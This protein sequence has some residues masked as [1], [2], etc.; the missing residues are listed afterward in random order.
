MACAKPIIL[1]KGGT[2]KMGICPEIIPENSCLLV[3]DSP[4]GFAKG[5]IYLLKNDKT[6]INIGEKARERI[7]KLHNWDILA[8]LY[9][10]VL[11]EAVNSKKKI[12]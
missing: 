6:R 1:P 2:D 12:K 8:E 9:R 5:I 11:Y 7:V 4:E 10:D 3:D